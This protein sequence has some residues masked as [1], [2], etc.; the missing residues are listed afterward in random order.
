MRVIGLI[1]LL[2]VRV[3]TA[4]GDLT[5]ATYN[6]HNY[7]EVDRMTESGYQMNAPKPEGEKTALRRVIKAMNADVLVMQEMGT[8]A[9]LRELQRDLKRD[10]IDYPYSGWVTGL[11]RDRHLAFLSRVKPKSFTPHNQIPTK[12]KKP[13][14]V[15]R[16]LLEVRFPFGSSELTVYSAHLKSK[17]TTDPSDPEAQ[18]QR[19][20]EAEAIRDLVLRAHSGVQEFYL[21]AGDFNDTRRSKPLRA[22]TQRGKRIVA[23]RL[24]ARDSEGMVWTHR[25]SREGVYSNLDYILVS[26]ALKPL[27][28]GG[29]ARIIDVAETAEASDHRPVL[30]KLTVPVGKDTPPR[31]ESGMTE[32]GFE[33]PGDAESADDAD[34]G[35]AEVSPAGDHTAE[36]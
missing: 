16:G 31:K 25:Y 11:D 4:R 21:I 8:E 9:H 12:G 2:V 23:H 19:R 36:D 18:Q 34:G 28:S 7:N 15:V 5:V 10:G 1:L 32:G 17:R 13:G 26:E 33:D 35:V 29:Q 20:R 14:R 24:E 27:V 30:V 3:A 6:V 22:L